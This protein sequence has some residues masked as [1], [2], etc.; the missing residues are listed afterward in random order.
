MRLSQS[1]S[2][3]LVTLFSALIFL[4][5]LPA[6]ATPATKAAAPPAKSA[7]S[8]PAAT[9]SNNGKT[10]IIVDQKS[11]TVHILINGKDVVTIDAKGLHVNGN[12]DYTG[13]I[14]DKG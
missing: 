3:I 7:T 4:I 8:K 5:A 11:D 2:S 6:C 10:K 9:A 13:T 14:T 12:V 1:K